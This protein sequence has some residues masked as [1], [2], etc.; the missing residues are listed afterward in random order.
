MKIGITGMA[1]KTCLG[2][3]AKDC[4]EAMCRKEDGNAALKGFDIK[5]YNSKN[6]YEIDDRV[7]GKDRPYR[8]SE[9]LS[10]V[11]VQAVKDSGIN[12]HGKRCGIFIGTGLREL[13]SVELWHNHKTPIHLN[14]LHFG[15][16]ISEKLSFHAPVYTFCNACSA[17]NFTLGMAMDQLESGDLDFAIVG[18]IDSI[19]ESMFGL[20]DRVNSM[21]PQFLRSFNKDRRGVIMGEGAV[22]VVLE[23]NPVTRPHAWL[24]GVGISCDAYQDTAPHKEGLVAAMKNASERSGV[25]SESIDMLFVHGT[26]TILNDQVEVSAVREYFGDHAN[27]LLVT[28]IKPNIGH[29][30]GA[31]GLMSVVIAIN[32]L[33]HGMVPPI[34]GL[35][36]PIDESQDM[37]LLYEPHATDSIKNIQINAF[38]FGGV[39]AVAI[40]SRS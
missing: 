30:S 10:D 19:T 7:D 17:S 21:H 2:E 27:K 20:L 22:A 4:Y 36:D 24:K 33:L 15:H 5:K 23:K 35:H 25:S 34:F 32:S 31:S 9:W 39:N 28:G 37:K 13:R 3:T 8:A 14:K 29:T 38:G 11:V 26:G 12:P 18:G 40:L 16:A 6:A 1:A